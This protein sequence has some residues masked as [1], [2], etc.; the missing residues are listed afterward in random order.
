[1]LKRLL[2]SAFATEGSAGNWEAY[3]KLMLFLCASEICLQCG[4]Y[5]GC[6]RYATDAS[7]LS[8]PNGVLFFSHLQLCRAYLSIGDLSAL[9]VEYQTCL[10][11]GTCYAIGWLLLK[12]LGCTFK[13]KS[14]SNTI[15]LNFEAC[16]KEK[17]SCWDRWTALL[18]L[19]DIQRLI[20]DQEFI[21]AEALL[22]HICSRQVDAGLLFVHGMC[23][24]G[25]TCV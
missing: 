13:S 23:F 21:L 24:A 3:P 12:F 14:G 1:M 2:V 20:S 4:D 7:Q 8:L 19:V 11:I 9:Q 10:Q 15:D 25:T 5:S 16:L 6:L 17:G 22:R 18:N